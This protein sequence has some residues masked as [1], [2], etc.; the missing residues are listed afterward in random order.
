MSVGCFYSSVICILSMQSKIRRK[1]EEPLFFRKNLFAMGRFLGRCGGG[2]AAQGRR[3]EPYMDPRG[4]VL[5]LFLLI[6]PL[7]AI[8]SASA[9]KDEERRAGPHGES[10]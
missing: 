10:V 6:L 4:A 7:A 9:R 5:S 2:A 8:G 1:F 3:N